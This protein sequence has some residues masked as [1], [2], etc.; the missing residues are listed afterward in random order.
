MNVL[1]LLFALLS[2]AAC[3]KSNTDSSKTDLENLS[4]TYSDQQ[5][6][7]YGEAFGQRIFTFDESQW[8][9]R[10]TLALDPKL[11]FPVFEFRTF[12]TYEVLA[13]SQIVPGA[14]NAIFFENKKFL[15]LKTDQPELV[16]AFGFGN[17]QLE[18]DIEKDISETGCALWAAVAECN[19][20][21][22]LLKLDAQGQLY[23][24]QRPADNNM[25]TADHRPTQLTPPVTKQ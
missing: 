12:G 19:A 2:F 23:F 11:E 10:F 7:A 20:D 25:C 5:A 21:H 8:T 16:N 4:G 1:A 17:C 15:T 6:Y 24:G 14:Y 3:E 13:P 18:K 22:D 9:L